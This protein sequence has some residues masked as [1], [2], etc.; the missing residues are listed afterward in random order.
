MGEEKSEEKKEE[1]ETE[2][3]AEEE[4]PEE[5][6]EEKETEEKAEEDKPEE[7]TEGFMFHL[8][9]S[10]GRSGSH[11]KRHVRSSSGPIEGSEEWWSCWHTGMEEC[12]GGCC[13]K[14]GF[15]YDDI[16]EN[17]LDMNAVN[18]DLEEK[19]EKKEEKK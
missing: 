2:E 13:C 16:T 5:N 1:K 12:N 7:K 18:D 11:R 15:L 8:F 19:P 17:C 4:K 6:A 3:K 14:E 10:K 9:S